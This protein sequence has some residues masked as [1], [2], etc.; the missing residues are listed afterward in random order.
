M[1]SMLAL[2]IFI[3][4]NCSFYKSYRGQSIFSERFKVDEPR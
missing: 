2:L 3:N 1:Y 4:R